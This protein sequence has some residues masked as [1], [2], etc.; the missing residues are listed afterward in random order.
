LINQILDF[1]KLEAGEMELEVLDFDLNS[2]IEEVADLLAAAAHNKGL[3]L[4][5]LVH[6]DLP[7]QL[8]GDAPRLRQILTNLVSNAI[9]FTRVGEVVIQASLVSETATTATIAFSVID[10]GIGIAPEA[11]QKLFKPFSQVDASTTRRYG[12]TGLGLAISKQLVELMGGTIGV[13]SV[14]GQKTRFWVM[15]TIAKQSA[16]TAIPKATIPSLSQLRVLVVDD[17]ATSRQI[18][19]EQLSGWG[20][21]VD[22]AASAI[23]ALQ[24]LQTAA[25]TDPYDFAIVDVQMPEVDGETLASQIQATPA[26]ATL[27]LILMTSLN[28]RG[29]LGR[30]ALGAVAYLV[31]PIKQARLLDCILSVLAMPSERSPKSALDQF[32]P[33]SAIAPAVKPSPSQ[34]AS[35]GD[36]PASSL[37]ATAL[38]ILLVEDNPV[39]QKVTLNQLRNLGY[40]AD[41]VADGAAAIK[42]IA[43]LSYDLVL[44]DCQMPVMDGYTATREVRRLEGT[45]RHTVI[46]ALTANAMKEDRQP[47]IDAGMDDYLSKP[48]RKEQLAAKIRHWSPIIQSVKSLDRPTATP[49]PPPSLDSLIDWNHLHLLCDDNEE[50]ELELLETFVIDAQPRLRAIETA[51]AT[52]NFRCLEQ[53]AHHIKG[54]SANLGLR[55]MQAAANDLEQQANHKRLESNVL[56]RLTELQRSLNSIRAYLGMDQEISR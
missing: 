41:V 29:S 16:R 54:A 44:M 1:S 20:M 8:K 40:G 18:L 36:R 35:N 37:A 28:H 30:V 7:T 3:E 51:I 12:G 4:V 2:C 22:E 55:G 52:Q 10:T 19:R 56:E 47:C 11:Q 46:I 27:P 34:P 38:S 32:Q 21:E 13:E 39:N 24:T 6:R 50:F 26:I 9:K 45:T 49:L 15:V 48:I 23:A 53:E 25:A 33:S 43:A 42:Q 5:T 14:A 31:K 17:N